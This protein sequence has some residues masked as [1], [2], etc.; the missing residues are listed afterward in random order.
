MIM[1][2]PCSICDMLPVTTT[3]Q[4]GMDDICGFM[5][6]PTV[7]SGR[8]MSTYHLSASDLCKQLRFYSL[9]PLLDPSHPRLNKP[10]AWKPS[11]PNTRT[12][13]SKYFIRTKLCKKRKLCD[14]LK[15]FMCECMCVWRSR[16]FL[17][18]APYDHLST[19]SMVICS[20]YL[21]DDHIALVDIVIVNI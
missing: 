10:S 11:P 15:K 6:D 7:D 9:H 8:A 20:E 3:C 18:E 16:A 12:L 14:G 13:K 5:R 17:L 2:Y 1:W 4:R 19:W 21:I